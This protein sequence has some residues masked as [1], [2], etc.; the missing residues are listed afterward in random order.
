MEATRME[1]KVG[2]GVAHCPPRRR[3]SWLGIGV[4]TDDAEFLL[5]RLGGSADAFER[6][7]GLEWL[8]EVTS[9]DELHARTEFRQFRLQSLTPNPSLHPSLL[10]GLW[11]VTVLEMRRCD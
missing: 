6:F 4:S 11:L 5:Q 8:V 10:R 2:G 3:D 1:N 7:S 9:E